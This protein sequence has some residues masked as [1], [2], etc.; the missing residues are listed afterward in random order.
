[1]KKF[2][3]SLLNDRKLFDEFV[4]TPI[5][6]VKTELT[7]RYGSQD[8]D[9][10]IEMS[11]PKDFSALL[12]SKKCAILHRPLLTDNY[13]VLHFMQAVDSLK[14]EPVFLE[15]SSDKFVTRNE[16][17]YYLGRMGF[18]FGRGRNG[19]EKIQYLNCI[20]FPESDGRRLSDVKTLWGQSLIEFHHEIFLN[21]FP[22]LK[23][24]IF[25]GLEWYIHKGGNPKDY[26]EPFFRL[27]IS[28][29][30]LFE[31]FLLEGEELIFTKDII[32]PSLIKIREETGIKPLIVALEPTSSEKEGLW[33][34]HPPEGFES[35]K[36]RLLLIE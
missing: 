2:I 8:L 32:L 3:E 6:E 14:L 25:N 36:Q 22:N 13:E 23:E 24:N 28:H 12:K 31:N 18:Y 1:M 20:N 16:W 5:S 11:L 15:Y 9:E 17:K 10:Y 29:G 27:F 7:N 4:Y 30:V 21:R 26:Y 33:M 19:G 34:C 35:I